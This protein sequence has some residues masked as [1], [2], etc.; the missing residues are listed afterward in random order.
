MWTKS[1]LL[2]AMVG[3]AMLAVP[4]SAFAGRDHNFRG[5]PNAWHDRGWHQGW[6]GHD[7]GR[8]NGWNGGRFRQADVN[9]PPGGNNVPPRT[10]YWNPAPYQTTSRTAYYDG[11]PAYYQAPAPYYPTPAPAYSSASNYGPPMS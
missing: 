7:A 1:R 9:C 2:S 8:W 10:V 4:V 3:V 11:P 6:S 5:R